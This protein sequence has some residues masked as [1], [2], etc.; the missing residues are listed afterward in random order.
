MR[1]L[2][3]AAILFMTGSGITWSAAVSG[4]SSERLAAIGAEYWDWQMRNSPTWATY[5]GDHRFDEQLEDLSPRA[6]MATQARMQKFRARIAELDLAKLTPAER[7]SAGVL[8]QKLAIGLEG[9]A[10]KSHEYDVNQLDGPQVQLFELASFHPT[11][12]RYGFYSLSRRLE[13]IPR[14]L[15]QYEANLRDGLAAKRTAPRVIVER[16]IDQLRRLGAKSL[17]QNPFA[18]VI[19]KAPADLQERMTIAV[20]DGVMPAF[21]KLHRFLRDEYLPHARSQVGIAGMPGGA[22]VYKFQIRRETTTQL[23]AEEIHQIGLDELAKIHAEADVIAK[24]NGHAD[25]AA[26]FAAIR[27]D[28]KNY[29]TTREGVLEKYREA[30][31]RANAALPKV[32]A[33][34]PKAPCIVKPIE[35]FKERESPAAYYYSAPHDR[36][37]P[38]A[39]MANTYD[40]AS[41]PLYNATALTVHEA[42]P[43]HHLQIAIAQEMTGLPVWRRE[44]HFT[45]FTEGWGLYSERLADELGLYEND[46]ARAGMLTFQ[47]WRAC[48]LVVDTGMHAKGWT[49]ER[50]IAFMLE[51]LALS[52][53]DITAEVERYIIWPG[54]ALAYMIGMREIR[55]LRADAQA[56]LGPKFDLKAFHDV[57]LRNGAVPLAVLADEV[58]AWVE[59]V[60]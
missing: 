19:R 49:R 23:T 10:V 12:D 21:A 25:A 44:S 28:P 39:F 43:G 48:R 33:V 27:K 40:P 13:A 24:R 18:E 14:Y 6:R 50:S 60:R 47:A 8:D 36:S 9:I 16:V 38:A 7:V 58:G 56:K 20:R 15:A 32:F 57:V 35:E 42:V 46:L 54:Q 34:L 53:K 11:K 3:L 2:T 55:R 26:F 37:R 59:S 52:E 22:A 51:N 41:R 45:A 17:D 4:T 29:A 31:A 1:T 30:L 5:L